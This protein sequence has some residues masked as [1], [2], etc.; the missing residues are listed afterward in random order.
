MMGGGGGKGGV[1]RRIATV[2]EFYIQGGMRDGFCLRST[3]EEATTLE[4]VHK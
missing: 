4:L 2:G 1:A 3:G